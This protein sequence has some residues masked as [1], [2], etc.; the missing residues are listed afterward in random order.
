MF[1]VFYVKKTLIQV[2]FGFNQATL[3]YVICIIVEMKYLTFILFFFLLFSCRKKEVLKEGNRNLPI[4]TER[5][6][7]MF[8]CHIDEQTYI[9]KRQNAIVYN[10]T[11]GYLFLENG[12]DWFEFRLFV[13]NGLFGTGTYAFDHTGEEWVSSDFEDFFWIKE[14]GANELEITKLNLEKEVVS[15]SFNI[16]LVD[17]TGTIK[18]VRN[19]RF[20]LD[21]EII[22]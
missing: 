7:G 10:S 4:A 6:R 11:T 5:G 12:N 3:F 2:S 21:L 14:D 8:A 19:G 22:N 18:R 13:Y 16:D 9:A 20:D 1:R 17:S 15:G